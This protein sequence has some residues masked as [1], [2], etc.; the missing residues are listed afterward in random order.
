MKNLSEIRRNN[1][2]ALVEEHGLT[3]VSTRIKRSPSQV[4]DTIAGR[5]SFG[6]KIARAIEAEWDATRQP[7][8]LDIEHNSKSLNEVIALPKETNVT[9]GYIRLEHL[10]YQPSMGKGLIHDGEAIV[11]HLDV[12][13]SFVKQKIGTVNPKRIKLLTGVGQSM[14]PTI[15]DQ[16]IIFVDVEHRWIDAPGIYV[17][18]VAGLLLLKKALILSS[19]VLVLRSDNI[20]EYPDEEKLDLNTAA[21]S[22]TVCGKVLAWWTL[23]KG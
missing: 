5:K 15:C 2:N 23:N 18:D 17:I 14:M 20:T 16:D 6:E 12:L 1:L 7:G 19:G 8:W 22:I 9:D 3:S 11:Q 21:D 10:P 13:E 4:S